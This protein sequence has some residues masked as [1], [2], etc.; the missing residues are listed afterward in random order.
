[1]SRRGR[2]GKNRHNNKHPRG[3]RSF[4]NGQRNES[5]QAGRGDQQSSTH[6]GNDAAQGHRQQQAGKLAFQSAIQPRRTL[7]RPPKEPIVL[8]RGTDRVY[9]VAFYDTLI[10]A[11]NDLDALRQLASECDQLNIVVKAEAPMDDAELSSVGK[12]FCGAAWAL[13]HERR[14]ADGWY[15]Q[16]HE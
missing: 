10:Q 12:L 14:K 15:D 7:N 16:R 4:V 1:M 9:K 8:E 11:K 2:G 13:I 5:R 3:D 6:A